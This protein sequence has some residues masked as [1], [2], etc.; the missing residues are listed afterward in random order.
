MSDL[1]PEAFDDCFRPPDIPTEVFC[2]HCQ[3]TYESY[4]IW[5][6]EEDL[7]DR[8]RGFWHCPTHGCDGIGFGF[9]IWP[10]DPEYID[11]RTGERMCIEYSDDWDDD[12]ELDPELEE[13]VEHDL[14][15]IAAY[16]RDELRDPDADDA[17]ALDPTAP[18]DEFWPIIE[19]VDPDVV[20]AAVEHDLRLILGECDNGD[21]SI[22]WDDAENSGGL[23][24]ADDEDR[25]NV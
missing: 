11:P 18:V 21:E 6:G 13:A 7:G 10:V 19:P 14:E 24:Y 5:W 20:A 12:G 2:L 16:G 3:R 1:P 4:L 22:P 9:D 17:D 15:I 25:F 8:R 23:G